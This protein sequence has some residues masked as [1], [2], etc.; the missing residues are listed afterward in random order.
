MSTYHDEE[1]GAPHH[2]TPELF[3]LLTLEGAQAGLNWLTI[4]RRRESY[5]RA[6]AFYNPN[7]VAA[8]TNDDVDRLKWTPEIGHLLKM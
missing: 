8:Y 1:W 6:F 4:L 5:R 7:E 3:E 2:D